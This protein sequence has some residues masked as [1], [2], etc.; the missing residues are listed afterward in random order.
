VT[1]LAPVHLPGLRGVNDGPPGGAAER[2]KACLGYLRFL[3]A[4]HDPG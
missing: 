4:R 1:G 3:N 2:T